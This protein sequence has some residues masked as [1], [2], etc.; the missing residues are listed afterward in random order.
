[1]LPRRA[2]ALLLAWSLFAGPAGPAWGDGAVASPPLAQRVVSMNPSLTS[3]LVA[4]DA[5]SLLVGVEEHSARLHPGLGS[6]PVVGGLFNP[7]LEAVVALQPDLVVL[8]PSAEQRDFRG[9]LEALGVEVLVL[10]NVAM[11]DILESIR[12]L[13]ER[14][15]RHEAARQRIAEIRRS[16]AAI[17]AASAGQRPVRAVVVLQRDP[18]YVV[19]SG[20]FIDEMLG[21]AGIVNL[22]R[23]LGEPYPRASVEWLIAAA[24]EL[25]LDASDGPPAAAQ[26]WKRWPSIPAVANGHADALPASVTFPGPFIDRSLELIAER[27]RTLVDTGTSAAR[28]GATP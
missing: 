19:G 27:V 4:L 21:Q 9:R 8:V 12:V 18:L 26:F 25:I 15:G 22:G 13:G 2:A 17:G 11:D 23:E 14:V 3:T 16:F 6:I 20:S 24:P 5:A 28:T 7:S 10:P 1:M